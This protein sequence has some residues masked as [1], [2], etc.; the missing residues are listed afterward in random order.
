MRHGCAAGPWLE[1]GQE[2]AEKKEEEKEGS[3]EEEEHSVNRK[4][5]FFFNAKCHKQVMS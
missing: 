1:A 5:C 3:G 4:Q 2:E